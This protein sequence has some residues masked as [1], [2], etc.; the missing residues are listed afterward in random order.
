MFGSTYHDDRA[1]SN[2]ILLGYEKKLS[3]NRISYRW[4]W[5]EGNSVEETWE[6]ERIYYNIL[7]EIIDLINTR[8]SHKVHYLKGMFI[9]FVSLNS[10]T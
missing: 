6:I 9:N 7:N 10:D 3:G 2:G 1:K 5:A 8:P 4:R